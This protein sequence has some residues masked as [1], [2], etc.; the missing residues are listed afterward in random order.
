MRINLAYGAMLGI[1]AASFAV[2]G[3]TPAQASPVAG[4]PAATASHH[5]VS[6]IAQRSDRCGWWDGCC[7]WNY[8]CG[9]YGGGYGHGG[10][11]GYGGYGHGGYGGYGHGGYGH[12]G[13]GHG[14]Y[15][16]GG[17][18]HGGHGY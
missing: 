1:L 17:Y 12:G 5:A 3:P 8:W 7:G 11:G 6:A 18:G 4:T 15:G 10:Y 9:G 14:G 2:L 16:H 13:Y